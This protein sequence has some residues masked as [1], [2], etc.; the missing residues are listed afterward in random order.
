MDNTTEKTV[1]PMPPAAQ[2]QKVRRVGTFAFGL[3]LIAAGVLLLCTILMPG[4]DPRPVLRLAPVILIALGIEVL[5]YAARPGIKLKY[6]F[7][8]MLGCAF[9]LVVVGGASLVPFV[10]DW[11]GP[12]HDTRVR[13]LNNEFEA[14]GTAALE[15]VPALR[16][17]VY[18]AD[19]Y[20][21]D[22]AS[23]LPEEQSIDLDTAVATGVCSPHVHFVL[24]P[25]YADADAFA[26][27]CAKVLAACKGLPLDDCNFT[28]YEPSNDG[29]AD[30][31]P[32]QVFSLNISS[33]W[34]QDATAA[35]LAAQ[36][37]VNWHYRD[38]VFSN[39]EELDR[40]L[41]EEGD[42]LDGEEGQPPLFQ[43]GY[44]EGYAA[45]YDEGLAAAQG[46][47]GAGTAP[48]D[49]P[50][51]KAPKDAPGQEAPSPADGTSPAS[52]PAA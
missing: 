44:D 3:T 48:E 38:T 9:I 41:A 22:F 28:T 50:E 32:Y 21:L 45:G 25:G 49:A 46:A 35:S 26:A 17:C 23:A 47:A 42:G 30:A 36:V 6:D 11:A 24:R 39:R 12:G 31:G 5:V 19:F 20:L 29:A 16:D 51:Q 2:P 15:A 34:E 40:F 13:V 52:A 8:S 33:Q 1:P 10:W 18:Q 27:D 4:F 37:D 14:R 7:L 43:Q